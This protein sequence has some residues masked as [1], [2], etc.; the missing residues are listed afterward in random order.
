MVSDDHYVITGYDGV[1][2]WA[3]SSS[4]ITVSGDNYLR[5]IETPSPQGSSGYYVEVD[6]DNNI[7]LMSGTGTSCTF[8]NLGNSKYLASANSAPTGTG[9]TAT[10][11]GFTRNSSSGGFSFSMKDTGRSRYLKLNTSG[12]NHYFS[13]LNS[14]S[15]G[16]FVYRN[17]KEYTSW[18]HCEK[19]TVNYNAGGGTVSGPSSKE[20]DAPYAGVILPDASA[21]TDCRKE[22][23]NFAGWATAPITE[24]SSELMVDLLPAGTHYRLTSDGITLYAVYYQKE[25]TYKK[26]T[27]MDD[28]K[29]GVNY[30]I[31][32]TSGS[33]A[34]RAVGNTPKAT[35]YID[36]V[37][38]TA[39][40]NTITT[41]NPSIQWR[42]QRSSNG[43]YEFFN[44]ADNVYW[45]LRNLGTENSTD[46]AKLTSN[47]A[48]D[49][50]IISY[51]GAFI[52]RSVI[53]LAKEIKYLGYD[54]GN[55]RFKTVNSDNLT[56]L[57]FYQQ[58]A[59]YHSN[60]SCIQA[61]DALLWEKT[62]AGTYV[63]LES[64][65]LS[66]APTM[67]GAIGYPTL[68]S[69]GTYKYKYDITEC[70]TTTVTWDGTT[71]T[72][73]I[74]YIAN[75]DQVASTL[76]PS[77]DC[78][79]CDVVVMPDKTLTINR[80][81][82][83]HTLTLQ[84]GA[85]LNVTDGYTLTVNSLV[86]SANGDQKSPKV[87]LNASGN[88]E[89]EHGELYYDLRIPNDRYYWFALP[90]STKL[91]DISYSNEAA[92]GGKPTLNTDYY[93]YFYNG[94]LRGEDANGGAQDATYWHP[95]AST[96]INAGQ[97]YL[98]GLADDAVGTFNSQTYSHTK[99]VIR[100]AMTPPVSTW[101]NDERSSGYKIGTVAP[102]TAV[103]PRNAV[104]MGWNLIGNPYMH[105][106]NTGTTSGLVNG[107]WEK[108]KIGDYETNYYVQKT[109]TTTIPYVTVYDPSTDTYSQELANSRS[110]RPFEAVFVQINEGTGLKFENNA[111]S[112]PASAPA[113]IRR[114]QQETPV[115]TGIKLTGVGGS[116]KT[117]FVLSD[118][119]TPAYEIGA[120][121]QKMYAG[122]MNLYSINADN[123]LLAFNGLSEEDA[124]DPIPVGVTFPQGGEYVF[125]FDAEQYS[126]NEIEALILI[127]KQEGMRVNLKN[128]YYTFTTNAG[129]V[130]DRF[131][132]IIRLAKG[133]TT[134][135]DPVGFEDGETHK[136]I[137]DNHLYIIRD[138]EMYNAMGG[139]VR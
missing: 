63:T 98:F 79:S 96:T 138:N 55:T 82:K 32:T 22:G 40:A 72:L 94:K 84:E 116:D 88:I 90:Y 131:A 61:S 68:Q 30:I 58:E 108:E 137:K 128:G 113:Y 87:N 51:S 78:P 70:S 133:T 3:V 49:N 53:S 97:G 92:N 109:G 36:A 44:T 121:L 114:Q 134:D 27:S 26:I 5:G 69:D 136:I 34:G 7:W 14:S 117:G 12:D 16:I 103:N 106:Y 102:T 62:N 132:I 37:S 35:N 115:R 112:V 60:P 75:S 15:A 124:A 43:E 57:Y 54:S 100:F 64:Y 19:F 56:A 127:D 86:L 2:D 21:N 105:T 33:S 31:A 111:M 118:E 10:T 52:I 107:E 39:T 74:P 85:T 67:P 48:K 130:N 95:V 104:H 6:D 25:D 59:L 45:D 123:Q 77:G 28:L 42:I 8:R 66:G 120:D 18:P 101:L 119:Y 125:S 76:L 46:Y 139:R 38:V 50:F 1:M 23:W 83:L 41:T 91:S 110:L 17:V 13:M 9:N 93:L 89:L 135:I 71:S 122:T 126:T 24:E 47:E 99:R 29:M 81:T 65:Q 129:T 4:T 20:E 73:R 11:Y 80:N